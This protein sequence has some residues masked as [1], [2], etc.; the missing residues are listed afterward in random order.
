MYKFSEPCYVYPRR[1]GHIKLLASVPS[2][3]SYVVPN[4]TTG[5]YSIAIYTPLHRHRQTSNLRT[6]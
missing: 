3:L 2:A 1:M 4:V 6:Y 5:Y